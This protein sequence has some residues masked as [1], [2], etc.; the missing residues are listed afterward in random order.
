M[1]SNFHLPPT[2]FG[3]GSQPSEEEAGY[4]PLPS[5]MRTY[6]PTLPEVTEAEAQAVAPA[7]ALLERIAAACEASATGQDGASL[8]LADLAPDV[9]RLVAETLGQGEVSMKIGGRPAVAVQESVFAGVW[10]V[11]GSGVDRV[12]IGPV[13]ARALAA[14]D[15]VRAPQGPN[16]PQFPGVV[17]APALL[18]ELMDKS[19]SYR[20]GQ[21]P[22]VINL[23]LLPHTE[24]DLAWLD[25]ALGQGS[26]TILSRGYGNCRVTATATPHVWRV[27]FFNSMDTLILDTFEVTEMPEVALAAPEDLADSAARLREVMEAIR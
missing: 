26:V 16:A 7:L 11:L 20:P 13:P 10:Q 1:V 12:E 5:G 15:P 18:V 23:T 8:Q 4:L 14:F 27:Q 17:N 24:A 2:G 9:R 6:S 21:A 22:H 3:P 19:A 25:T